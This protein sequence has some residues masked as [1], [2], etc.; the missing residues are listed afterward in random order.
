MEN[1][2]SVRLDDIRQKA[3]DIITAAFAQDKI[4]ME[5]YEARADKIQK[6]VAVDTIEAQVADLPRSRMPGETPD[7]DRQGLRQYDGATTRDDPSGSRDGTAKSREPGGRTFSTRES[8][9][10]QGDA[11]PDFVACVMGERKLTGDWLTSDTVT[12][13]TFMGETTIDLRDTVLPRHGLKI[14]AFAMMGEI[15][16]IVPEGLPVRMSAVPF[17]GEAQLHKSVTRRAE[18]G[19]PWVEVSGLAF[20]GSINVKAF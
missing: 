19:G 15:R 6:A 1:T 13:I 20:M 7:T 9:A 2:G 4:T 8:S 14:Q 18:A 17:M 10:D 11:P 3:L 5:E 12:S 16:I